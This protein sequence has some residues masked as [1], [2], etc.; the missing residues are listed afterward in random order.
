MCLCVF[1][2]S[3]QS[4]D[5]P[6]SSSLQKMPPGYVRRGNALIRV[7]H[8][9]PKPHLK[10]PADCPHK[11]KNAYV[12][13][14][15][16]H[17]ARDPRPLQ[18]NLHTY[19]SPRQGSDNDAET[20]SESELSCG[21][22]PDIFVPQSKSFK[23]CL[24]LILPPVESW[25]VQAADPYAGN[26][27][28]KECVRAEQ[29]NGNG[30]RCSDTSLPSMGSEP[31]LAG[32][33]MLQNAAE[34]RGLFIKSAVV[35]QPGHTWNGDDRQSDSSSNISGD[36]PVYVTSSGDDSAEEGSRPSEK[37]FVPSNDVYSSKKYIYSKRK[38]YQLIREPML[39]NKKR[40][41]SDESKPLSPCFYS[42]P[43]AGI[44]T[45]LVRMG[46][47]VY[48]AGNNGHSRKLEIVSTRNK[49]IQN[50]ADI[51]VG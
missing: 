6:Q 16:P 31:S 41:R 24:D 2:A 9:N 17:T 43:P 45:R 48:R 28:E 5:E 47:K 34:H 11:P 27:A 14:Q 1:G 44:R 37:T 21:D 30:T 18:D 46:S 42:E 35:D 50:G 29:G 8:P 32:D 15:R 49:S 40:F 33:Y 20:S 10:G 38:A 22:G 7:D 51:K 23:S 13:T 4:E 39:G 19:P 26:K 36:W 25:E 12:D 3:Q